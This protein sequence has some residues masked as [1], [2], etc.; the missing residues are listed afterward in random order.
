MDTGG[1]VPARTT[2]PPVL[3]LAAVV[4]GLAAM[5]MVTLLALPHGMR[6]ALVV[7]E[8]AL[9]APGLLALL[10]YRVPPRAP[11]GRWPLDGRTWILMVAAGASLWLASLGLL[12]LQY[13][14]WAPPPGY[15]E[16]FRRLHEALKPEGPADALVSL[17]AVALL[18]ALC[19]ELLVR[20]IVLPSFSTRSAPAGAVVISAVVF[21]LIHLDPYR[22]LFTLTLGLALG[23]LRV[24]TGSLAACMAAHAV[25]NALTFAIA[26]FADDPAQGLPDPRPVLGLGLL[27]AGSAAT[28]LVWRFL[29]PL[30]PLGPVPRLEA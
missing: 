12:E 26:P 7:S 23:S 13:A 30:T 16:M 4:V 14:V 25:L 18:P 22:T 11:L 8:L 17:A 15:L 20:G 3:A 27:L 9:V 21:A 24:R 1:S 28:V 5:A 19:E 6:L 29:P 10:A 2:I